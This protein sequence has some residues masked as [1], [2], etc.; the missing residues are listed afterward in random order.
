M[1]PLLTDPA[2]FAHLLQH[3]FAERLLQQKNASPLK[4]EAY[5]DTFCLLLNYS[6]RARGKPPA[7]L[8]LS[9]SWRIEGVA[10]NGSERELSKFD[11]AARVFLACDTRLGPPRTLNYLWANAEPVGTL[12]PHPKSSRAQLL[13]LESGNAKAG[14]WIGEKVDVTADWKRGFP[15]KPMPRLVGVGLMTD[16]DSLDQKLTGEYADLQLTGD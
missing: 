9:W 7:K 12:L 14:R 6:E 1:N 15:G 10:T 4:V 13:I 16:G 11:H 8:T 2:E 5:R 3:F